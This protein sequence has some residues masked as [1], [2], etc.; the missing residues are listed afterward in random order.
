MVAP[1]FRQQAGSYVN[2]LPLM[3]VSTRVWAS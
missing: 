3:A 2:Q 1:F